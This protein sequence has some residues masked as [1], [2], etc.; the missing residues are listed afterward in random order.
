MSLKAVRV[1]QWVIGALLLVYGIY[2]IFGLQEFFGTIAII[3]AFFIFPSVGKGRNSSYSN[4]NDHDFGKDTERSYDG[5]D[6][7]WGSDSRGD[8]GGD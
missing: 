6:S 1:I 3:A 4:D 2:L 8:G 7:D 5:G